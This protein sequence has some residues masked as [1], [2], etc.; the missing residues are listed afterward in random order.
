MCSS[1]LS[2]TSALD[3]VGSRRHASAVLVPGKNW[4]SLYRGLGGTP[5][6]LYRSTYKGGNIL[7]S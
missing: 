7:Y 5:A 6:S 1:T 3:G 4:Y 2:S